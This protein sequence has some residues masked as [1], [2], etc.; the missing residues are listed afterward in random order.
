RQYSYVSR[1]ISACQLQSPESP[2]T[3]LRTPRCPG[4]LLAPQTASKTI[5]IFPLVLAAVVIANCFW[6]IRSVSGRRVSIDP[7]LPLIC[8]VTEG[9]RAFN[10]R[11]GLNLVF[12]GDRKFKN[13]LSAP[14]FDNGAVRHTSVARSITCRI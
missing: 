7:C 12:G 1:S 10:S 9:V 11:C 3:S 14:Q 2:L 13:Q 6:G 5:H 4:R 8:G